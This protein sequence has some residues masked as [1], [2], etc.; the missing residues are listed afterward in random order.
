MELSNT[1]ETE[2]RNEVVFVIVHSI[3]SIS[4]PSEDFINR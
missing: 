2:T 1:D 3:A 4:A